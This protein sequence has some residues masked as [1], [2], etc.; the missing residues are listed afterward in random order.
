MQ[1][2]MK[3][4]INSWLASCTLWDNFFIRYFIRFFDLVMLFFFFVIFQSYI[5]SFVRSWITSSQCHL[6]CL[7]DLLSS[8]IHLSY[9]ESL[10]RS[11]ITSSLGLINLF[12]VQNIIYCTVCYNYI[13]DLKH[14]CMLA[15]ECFRLCW[16]CNQS[17]AHVTVMLITWWCHWVTFYGVS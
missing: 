7:L 10:V 6:S 17:N 8:E 1:I 2:Q 14:K 13:D 3:L 16:G 12:V 15:N 5:E 4:N 11:S 9:R